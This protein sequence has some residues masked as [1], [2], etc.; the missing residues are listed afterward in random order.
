VRIVELLI[1]YSQYTVSTPIKNE[2]YM[3]AS[4]NK[5]HLNRALLLQRCHS[6]LK[7]LSVYRAFGVMEL[8]SI[9][10]PTRS[11]L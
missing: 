11:V 5:R 8:I 10:Q 9:S 7:L 2:P 1:L 4:N 6:I 3:F